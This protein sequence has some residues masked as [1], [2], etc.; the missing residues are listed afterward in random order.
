VALNN[1][2]WLLAQH[3][4]DAGK[5]QEALGFIE[6][7]I[8]GIGRRVDLM[9]TRGLVRL[10]LGQNEAALADFREAVANAPTAGNLFHLAYAHYKTRDKNNAFKVF[11]QAQE[12]GLQASNLHP[13]EQDDYQRL[14]VELNVR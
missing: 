8:D 11:K 2:A 14:R 13:C 12:Q 4:K 6:R 3:S 7:A 5:H 9:D 1:L 10:K